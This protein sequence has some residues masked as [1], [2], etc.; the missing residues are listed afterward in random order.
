MRD[1]FVDTSFFIALVNTRDLHHQCAVDLAKRYGDDETICH[2]SVPVLFELADG[3]ARQTRREIGASLLANIMSADNY[4]VHPFSGKTF[5]N[6]TRLYRT[7]SDKEWSLTD[8]YSFELMKELG[9]STALTADRH[10]EQ[11]GFEAALH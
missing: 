11:A 4:V 8:C 3:F 5:E 1:V 6:A 7:R 9:V 2:L 10:F